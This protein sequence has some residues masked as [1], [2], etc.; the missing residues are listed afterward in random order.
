MVKIKKNKFPKTLLVK[1]KVASSS[2]NCK[3][4][5]KN[6]NHPQVI[7]TLKFANSYFSRLKGLMFKKKLNYALVLKPSN[8]K[9]RFFSSIHT[10]FI[11]FTMDVVFLNKDQ[12]VFE[13]IQIS[14]W[15]FY[16]PKGPANYIIEMEKGVIEKYKIAIGDKLNFV[17]ESR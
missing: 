14:P 3:T 1:I 12:V 2:D 6:C 9:Y 7:A 8:S 13:I 5:Y 10:L 4:T 16:I 17:C 11:R 15:K